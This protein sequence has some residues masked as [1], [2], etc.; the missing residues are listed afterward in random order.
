MSGQSLSIEVNPVLPPA[1]SRLVDLATNLRFAWHHPTRRL[2]EALDPDL[3]ICVGGNPL[4]FLR[5]VAQERLDRAAEDPAFVEEYQRVLAGLDAYLSEA[6]VATGPNQLASGDLVAYFCAEYGFHESFP[7]YSGGLGVLAGDHCKTASDLGLSF[8]GVGLLYRQGYFTQHV[9]TYGNQVEHYR[10]FDQEDLPVE[11]ARDAQGRDLFTT[12]RLPGRDVRVR[13]WKVRAGR[14]FVIMLDTNLPENTEA[15]REIT[16]KLY[17]GNQEHRIRQ[18]IVLGIGGVKALR[19]LGLK[20]TTW[21][22]NEGH[23]AFSGLELV[24]ECVDRGLPFD[25]ACEAVAAQ[26]VF[27]T[28]TPVVAGHDAF[29]REL[30]LAYFAEFLPRLGVGVEEFL[31]LGG[32]EAGGRFNMTQLAIRL[33]RRQN[34]VSRTHG[35]VSQEICS[36]LWPEV[37]ARDNPIGYITNGVH[38]PTFLF[39]R[40]KDVFE[41][42]FGHN[43]Q[44]RLGD[45]AY[46]KRIYDIPDPLFNDVLRSVKSNMMRFV[47]ARLKRGCSREKVSDAHF[48]RLTRYLDPDNPDVLVIGFA[49]RFATYKRATL[50][51]RDRGWLK[52]LVSDPARPVVFIF[53]GKAHPADEPGKQMIRELVATAASPEFLGRVLFIEDYDVGLARTLIAGVDVWLNNPI[54]PLEASGTSGMKAA[55]NGTINLSVLDGWWAEAFDG[56]NGWAIPSSVA[57]QDGRRDDEDARSLYELLQDEVI[58]LYYQRDE[59]G[60]PSAWIAKA[61]HSMATIIPAFNTRRMLDNYIQGLYRPAS[62]HG[63]RLTAD[64]G[65][66]ALALAEWK[67]RVRACWAGVSVQLIDVERRRL[68]YGDR[69]R[70]RGAVAL[71]GL[72]PDDVRVE[73]V[74]SKEIGEGASDSHAH[75]LTSFA[76]NGGAVMH[77][78]RE[79][80][81][82]ALE[83]TG[84]RDEEGR[85][86]FALDHVPVW[87]GRMNCQLRVVPRHDLLAHPC[88]MGLMRV[89]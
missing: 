63:R 53:A 16:H 4:L 59:H 73:L 58:P 80:A 50:L 84:E 38:V 35:R 23:A 41:M 49:R 36:H 11:P 30:A 10:E 57:D 1:L 5:S 45:A 32:A 34:G 37:P 69:L 13:L 7:N 47:R 48:H 17:G 44:S 64:D 14:V 67:R 81:I 65:R 27:T 39:Q 15:D 68:T 52:A 6:I 61:K 71:N 29:D 77:D 18:E 22:L 62:E 21:H 72:A 56:E 54:P 51:F 86:L 8:V 70:L 40:W 9:D 87:C 79:V 12:V 88:E 19:A 85:H 33:S 2:F 75:R 28:H 83:P 82:V 60:L 74:V 26:T 20:P 43:W 25:A 66:A 55:I 24:A 78:G 3:W 76:R 31:A 46:W 89:S 42:H